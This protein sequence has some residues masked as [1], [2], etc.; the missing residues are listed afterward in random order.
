MVFTPS[1]M[2]E[3]RNSIFR[4][5]I[6]TAPRPD[7]LQHTEEFRAEGLCARIG[8]IQAYA[9]PASH[10]INRHQPRIASHPC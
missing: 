1:H 4:F 7:A 5:V 6:K 10:R 9:T 2:R 8:P 3:S